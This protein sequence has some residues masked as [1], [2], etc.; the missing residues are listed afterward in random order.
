M[1]VL[2]SQVRM[3]VMRVIFMDVRLLFLL[4][5]LIDFATPLLLLQQR[6]ATTGWRCQ[7]T[8][9]TTRL[10]SSNNGIYTT[11][12]QLND[13]IRATN[14]S[15]EATYALFKDCSLVNRETANLVVDSLISGRSFD[16]LDDVLYTLRSTHNIE[17]ETTMWDSIIVAAAKADPNLGKKYYN[18]ML[19]FGPLVTNLA[20]YE[21]LLKSFSRVENWKEVTSLYKTLIEREE[22]LEKIGIGWYEMALSFDA[23]RG[24]WKEAQYWFDEIKRRNLTPSHKCYRLAIDAYRKGGKSK[25]AMTYIDAML[26]AFADEG[27]IEESDPSE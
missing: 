18:R 25:E 23:R 20:T 8:S 6:V 14:T 19:K 16:L 7:P 22:M 15:A 24:R 3:V 11:S 21:M 13:A 5:C 9:S 26:E 2:S 27:S 1:S 17:T 12:E 10:H 4:C